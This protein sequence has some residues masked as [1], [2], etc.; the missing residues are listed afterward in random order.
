MYA[1]ESNLVCCW[2]PV[3][4]PKTY[5]NTSALAEMC[6]NDMIP[7]MFCSEVFL[8]L[9]SALDLR[10]NKLDIILTRD[11]TYR[12]YAGLVA[13]AKVASLI[14]FAD[15]CYYAYMVKCERLPG[16]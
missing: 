10:R 5:P 9:L 2:I 16:D 7:A 4:D 14:L 13:I 15:A 8:S 11:I 6:P 12:R 3:R 1:A